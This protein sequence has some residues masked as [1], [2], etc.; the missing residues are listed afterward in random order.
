MPER[1]SQPSSL[2]AFCAR[3]VH[4]I[5]EEKWRRY[6][7][8]LPLFRKNSEVHVLFEKRAYTLHQQ[9]SETSFP[10]GRIEAQETALEAAVRETCEELCVSKEQIRVFGPTDCYLSHTQRK[11]EPFIGALDAYQGTYSTDEVAYPFSVPLSVLMEAKPAVYRNKL[12]QKADEYFPYDLVPGGKDYPWEH[13][14][15]EI[16]FYRCGEEVIWGITARILH[17]ALPLI[18]AYHLAEYV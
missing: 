12:L 10:G 1:K 16:L 13:G 18:R 11:I 5:G 17:A 14:T 2:A 15:H 9:P 6:A 7:V 3:D 8:L 4:W